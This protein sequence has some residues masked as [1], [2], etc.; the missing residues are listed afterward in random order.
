[1]P[2]IKGI[3]GFF[4]VS[5]IEYPGHISSVVFLGGCD[6]RCPF[7][8]NRD[9]VLKADKID[10]LDFDEL[11]ETLELRKQM[12]E[13][14]SITGGEPL[15]FED[16]EKMI[17]EFKRLNLKIKID[18]NG[19][20]PDRLQSLIDSKLVD[21]AAMDIKTSL[22]RY[23]EGCGKKV[24]IPR[25]EKSIDILLAGKVDYEF[26]TTCVPTIVTEREIEL[27]S[28]RIQGANLYAL[29]QFR[30]ENL[31]DKKWEKI[32]PYERH[33]IKE[34]AEFASGYAKKV[35]VRGA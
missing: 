9:L 23:N 20:H 6:L 28:K 2:K 27:I 3:K 13:G 26:R 24:D 10:D 1:L 17:K 35:V 30:N 18:T 34:F 16:L 19:Y 14:V 21:Y 29:Q 32:S 4:G 25:I 31:L 33:V 8:Q 11:L 12:I 22:D 15:I 5:L 7:C